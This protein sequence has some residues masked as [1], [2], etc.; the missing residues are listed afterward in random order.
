[1]LIAED[2]PA[3]LP[4]F[5][6]RFGT[7]EQCQEL[8]MRL[9]WPDGFVCPGCRSRAGYRRNTRRVFQ[10][11]CGRQTSLTA[12]T[13][14][15]GTRKP[16]R[17]WFRAMFLMAAQKS[18]LSAKTLQRLMGFGSY[19]TAWSWLHKLRKAM[20]R[21]GR[22]KLTGRVEVDE[23][24]VGGVVEGAHGRGNP[25]PLVV[26]AVER[27]DGTGA[28]R[29]ALGRL[30]LSVV[31]DASAIS[32]VGFT[33][34][35]VEDASS[36]LTD[37][38]PSYAG[39]PK[40]GFD[41]R[42]HVIGKPKNASKLLPGVHRVFSLLKRWLLGTHQGAVSP[43]HLQAYLDE[44]VFRFNRR[45]SSHPGKLFHRLAEIAVLAEPFPYDAIVAR[46]A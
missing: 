2:F 19:Q 14:F 25:N 3:T 9:R 42:R 38:L 39:L 23:S 7:E 31:E 27:V 10:C 21:P 46:A 36:V 1:M 13:V 37:G 6:E 33:Q 43:K 5:E 28:P 17:L 32:L 11:P 35:N 4:E 22:P 29:P 8:L 18:G 15:E 16:L 41:H 34:A 20:V 24:F 30:R 44:F 26:G 12:G 40:A 45:K